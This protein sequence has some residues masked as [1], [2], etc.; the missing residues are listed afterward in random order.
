MSQDCTASGIYADNGEMRVW[1]V[2]QSRSRMWSGLPEGITTVRLGDLVHWVE[3]GDIIA[4]YTSSDDFATCGLAGAALVKSVEQ[5]VGVI[6]IDL[7]FHQWVVVPSS[8]VGRGKW[9]RNTQ[10]C[11]DADKVVN[12]GFLEWLTLVYPERTWEKK[13]VKDGVGW[14]IRFDPDKPRGD[15]ED[16]FV[17]LMKGDTS[18]KIGKSQD[19]LRRHKEVSRK[20]EGDVSLVHVISS[21]WHSRAEWELHERFKRKRAFREWFYLTE[22]DVSYICSLQEMN[23]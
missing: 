10:F 18:W 5:E 2:D 1:V 20:S 7:R 14:A 8:S 16:G 23:Y 22:E 9:R 15:D 12:Y 11:L 13:A 4:T 17:Y 6:T 3:P 21:N 19:P